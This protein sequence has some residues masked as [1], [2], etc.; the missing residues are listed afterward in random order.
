MIH[1]SIRMI[2]SGLIDGATP[3]LQFQQLNRLR[4]LLRRGLESGALVR[5]QLDLD[6]LFDAPRPKFDGHAE[7]NVSQAILAFQIG[8]AWQHT[9]LILDDRFDHLHHRA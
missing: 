2:R 7:I 9:F 6:N 5:R 3:A 8:S 1:A 4:D